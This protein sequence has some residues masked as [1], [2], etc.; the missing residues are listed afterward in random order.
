MPRSVG[1]NHFADSPQERF[2]TIQNRLLY[3]GL[4][5]KVKE[6]DIQKNAKWIVNGQQQRLICLVMLRVDD[7]LFTGTVYAHDVFHQCISSLSHSPVQLLTLEQKLT[8]LRSRNFN[9]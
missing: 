2:C 4:Y 9:E 7:L 8:F 6:Q 1:F 3:F 5:Q